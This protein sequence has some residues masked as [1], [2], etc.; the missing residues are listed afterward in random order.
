MNP[1]L[2]RRVASIEEE[3]KKCFIFVEEMR[4]VVKRTLDLDGDLNVTQVKKELMDVR[5]WV[6]T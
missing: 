2:T 4:L 3:I 5:S 6:R 1:E